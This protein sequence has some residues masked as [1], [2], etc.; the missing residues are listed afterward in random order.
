MCIA[1]LVPDPRGWIPIAGN[2]LS[3]LSDLNTLLVHK[4]NFRSATL[5]AC[6]LILSLPASPS[7]LAGNTEKHTDPFS[8][9]Q[10]RPSEVELAFLVKKDLLILQAAIQQYAAEFKKP[11]NA[12]VSFDDIKVY[13]RNDSR[14]YRSH[15]KDILGNP[16]LFSDIKASAAASAESIAQLPTIPT[17]YWMNSEWEVPQKVSK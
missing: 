15:G 5:A 11:E 7:L 10:W 12:A 16:Y 6:A 8:V 1:G 9:D 14:L 17:A 2:N 13:L 3:E 4:M